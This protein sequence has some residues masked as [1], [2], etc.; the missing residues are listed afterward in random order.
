MTQVKHKVAWT[1]DK[2]VKG[3]REPVAPDESQVESV[4]LGDEKDQDVDLVTEVT[5]NHNI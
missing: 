3:N 1:A 5:S 4:I 2:V